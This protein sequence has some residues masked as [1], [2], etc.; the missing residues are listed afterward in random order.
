M[1]GHYHLAWVEN[2]KSEIENQMKRPV[3]AGVAELTPGQ[4]ADFSGLLVERAGKQPRE[5]RLFSDCRSRAARRTAA[6]M[7]WADSDWFEPCER[8]WHS[9]EFYKL[10]AT[11]G[12]HEKF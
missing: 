11:Y 1:T 9:G 4:Y 7:A 10:R 12:E 6:Y 3:L 2:R 8:E 5:G